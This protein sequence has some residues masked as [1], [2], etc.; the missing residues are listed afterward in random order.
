MY[1]IQL[2]NVEL[3]YGE[4]ICVA[5]RSSSLEITK[6]ASGVETLVPER[7]EQPKVYDM[8]GQRVY[9]SKAKR[10]LFIVNGKKVVIK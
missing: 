4:A 7:Q 9:E 1:Q 6:N 3:S 5:D 10:G 8:R 2:S